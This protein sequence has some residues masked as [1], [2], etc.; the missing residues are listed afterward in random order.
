MSRVLHEGRLDGAVDFGAIGIGEMIDVV[1]LMGS[2]V[3][4]GEVVATSPFG[5]SLNN[6]AF[7]RGDLHLFVPLVETPTIVAADAI[8]SGPDDRVAS[9][10]KSLG[11]AVP[12]FE[13][14]KLDN[15]DE[16]EK[17]DDESENPVEKI[18]LANPDS[19]VDVDKLPGE[20]R[21]AVV[22]TTQMDSEQ[23]N[24]VMSEIGDS[25]VKALKRVNV[26]DTEV[27]VAAARIQR[28]IYRILAGKSLK[29]AGS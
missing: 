2:P 6:G 11:E 27:Y 26:K 24:S 28:A 25:V 29:K 23:L 15:R 7:Y 17:E 8:L 12:M 18:P 13:A 10:L 22:A 20:I 5:L 21:K 19:S 1:T 4:T 9:K 16:D 14:E 3:A